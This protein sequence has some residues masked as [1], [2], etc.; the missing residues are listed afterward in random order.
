MGR[1]CQNATA[2]GAMVCRAVTYLPRPE[3]AT[4]T[5]PRAAGKVPEAKSEELNKLKNRPGSCSQIRRDSTYRKVEPD[6]KPPH[7]LTTGRQGRGHVRHLAS[8][9]GNLH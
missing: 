5:T 1:C 9:L 4:S 6:Q 8:T 2:A 7:R 3:N